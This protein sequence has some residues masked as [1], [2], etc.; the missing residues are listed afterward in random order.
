MIA[1]NAGILGG[2]RMRWALLGT[3]QPT[4]PKAQVLRQREQ[5]CFVRSHGPIGGKGGSGASVKSP[6]ANSRG[7]N[8]FN[9]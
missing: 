9:P 2:V 4:R 8:K 3:Q 5:E 6:Y 1:E 7:V